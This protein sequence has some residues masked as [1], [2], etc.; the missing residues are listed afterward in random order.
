MKK[1]TED[2]PLMT[3]LKNKSWNAAEQLI[4]D[5]A[6]VN[7]ENAQGDSPL[8]LSLGP[9][10]EH[11]AAS[12]ALLRA[13]ADPNIYSPRSTHWPEPFLT[14]MAEYNYPP[15]LIALALERGADVNIKD[16]EERETPLF[17]ALRKNRFGQIELLCQ[18][19]AD[20]AV[21]NTY[22]QCVLSCIDTFNTLK[23]IKSLEILLK[24]GLSA[25]TPYGG[26]WAKHT[27]MEEAV[28]YGYTEIMIT[29]LN[30]GADI[31]HQ[32][33]LGRTP[34]MQ[35]IDSENTYRLLVANDADLNIQD[36]EGMT[37]IMHA[38]HY[39]DSDAIKFIFN[40]SAKPFNLGLKNKAGETARTMAK[41]LLANATDESKI[42]TLKRALYFIEQEMG[43]SEKAND[44]NQR[45]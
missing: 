6:E 4:R 1:I 38:L 12:A 30:H 11:F 23:G 13:G 42:W 17:A 39:G 10:P 44:S 36:N 20:L 32:D 2:T 35:G 41:N 14:G 31:N 28:Q 43:I 33:F 15:S 27:M 45:D 22:G 3:A 9:T 18:H 21:V 26:G 19:G 16:P 25:D 24:N 8:S 37:A 29:L 34:L 7:V 5:G 40:Y